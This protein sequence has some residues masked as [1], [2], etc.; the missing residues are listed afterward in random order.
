MPKAVILKLTAIMLFTAVGAQASEVATRPSPAP[1]PTPLRFE[2]L[3]VEEMEALSGGSGVNVNAMTTQ[4][5][6]GSS[7]G[8]TV[9]AETIT[10]GSVTFSQDALNGFNGVGNFV[11][12]TGANN[13]LQGAIN[14]SIVTAPGL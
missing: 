4:Q 7:S 11:I 5:L 12:N 1:P 2:T 6:T 13:T 9:T 8:N 14:L 3:S 10:S